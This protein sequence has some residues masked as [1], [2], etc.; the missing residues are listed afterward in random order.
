MVDLI[1]SMA[2]NF[3]HVIVE[4]MKLENRTKIVS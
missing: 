3:F 1:L 4:S 2:A